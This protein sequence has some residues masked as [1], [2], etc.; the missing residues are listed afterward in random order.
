[1]LYSFVKF[2]LFKLKSK[3]KLKKGNNLILPSNFPSNIFISGFFDFQNLRSA[4]Y[5]ISDDEKLTN[6]DINFIEKEFNDFMLSDGYK[7]LFYFPKFKEFVK[8]ITE[9][10]N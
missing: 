5:E 4:F 2:K 9:E 6:E 7:N 10:I 8:S 3:L 1:M